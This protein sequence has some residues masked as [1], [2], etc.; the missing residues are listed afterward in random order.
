[1]AV[2]RELDELFA[3]FGRRPSGLRDCLR[4]L[5]R[6]VREELGE[7]PDAFRALQISQDADSFSQVET[8]VREA[9]LSI[10]KRRLADRWHT[11][12]PVSQAIRY[13]EKNYDKP[14]TLTIL[15]NEVSLNYA[16]FSSIFKSRTGVGAI[17]YL[18]NL[19]LQKAK[20][21]LIST[22]DRVFEI[23]HK[24]GFPDERYFE[25]LFKQAEGV[26]PSEYR[27]QLGI[28]AEGNPQQSQP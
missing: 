5:E 17:S 15:A 7:N 22:D 4:R 2:A 16:Y 1:M 26:T 12:D 11:Q 3:G 27:R 14:L 13:M 20:E 9:L 24:T 10:S 28:L 6:F 8:R 18:Q 23:A 19:R 25:K 21:L